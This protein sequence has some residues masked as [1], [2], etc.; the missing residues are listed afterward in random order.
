MDKENPQ[1]YKTGN[2]QDYPMIKS[3]RHRITLI[4]L[5]LYW[6]TLFILAHIPMP[7][8]VRKAGVS[9]KS[10]HFL[11]YLILTF[12]LWFTI[13]PDEKVNWRK[14]TGWW[15]FLIITGYGA[16][17]EVIQHFVGRTCDA[18]DIAAN[19]T[20]I[21]TGLLLFSFLTFWPSALFVS[22][23]VIFGITNLLRV[24]IAELLPV[25]N[26]IFHFFAYAFFSGL[27][28]QNTLLHTHR[29]SSGIK[30]LVKALAAPAGLLITVKISAAI[31]GRNFTAPD[32]IAALGA[33]IAVVTVVYLWDLYHHKN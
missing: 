16:A 8:Y 4:L 19:I 17:D 7:Q 14:S 10:L 1:H 21:L 18:I 6:L 15:V 29:K 3:L 33:I 11:A 12:L 9:D 23:I 25:T 31:I 13:R 27:W 30:W 32:T 5:V 20:G 28:L 2:S 26:T 24:N 22:G